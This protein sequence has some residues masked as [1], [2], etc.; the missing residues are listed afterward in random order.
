MVEIRGG[1]SSDA[2]QL[3]NVI[4]NAE[5]SGYMLFDPGERKVAPAA[6]AKFI[7]TVNANEKSAVFI[8]EEDR[9]ILGYMFVQNEKPKRVS[10]R[11]YIVIGIHSDSRGKGIGKALFLHLFEWAK[12]VNL[13]RLDL[14]VIAKNEAAVALY[15]KV[16]FEIEGVKRDSLLIDGEYVDEYYMSKL[17]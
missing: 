1:I 6:F 15:K 17:I 5:D 16:G 11:A 9:E 13:H 3:V 12:K 10:H 7:D 8:A 14:T 4:K 2:D